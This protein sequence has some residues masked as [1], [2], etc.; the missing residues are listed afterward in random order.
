MRRSKLLLPVISALLLGALPVSALAAVPDYQRV[1]SSRHADAAFSTL[2]GCLLTEV[3]LGS[4]EA[5]FGGRPGP[6]NRQGLTD[7][8][9]RVSDT[10]Q[11]P[12]GKGYPI[13]A[14]WQGQTLDRLGSTPR[15]DVAW[16][17]A[18]IPV[19]DDFSG[20]SVDAVLDMTWT[21]V[22]PMDHDPGHL[23]TRY[24]HAAIANS[25]NNNWMRDAVAEGTLALDGAL[26]SLGPTGDAHISL[27]QYGCQVIV[28]PGAQVDLSC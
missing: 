27:V 28:H 6:V 11:P 8:S 5:V 12:A 24:P 1:I 25:H 19:S 16:I 26:L 13:V 14:M 10:C 18:V 7:V 21:A 17:H 2:D 4:T 23:H 20:R 22:G 9:V 3:F 15:L